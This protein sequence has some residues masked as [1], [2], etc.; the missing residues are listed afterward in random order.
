MDFRELVNSRGLSPYRLET[1]TGIR[2]DKIQ[3][4]MSGRREPSLKSI[5]KIAKAL[6]CHPVEVFESIYE[7]YL[8]TKGK[9]EVKQTEVSSDKHTSV[10]AL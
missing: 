2:H 5:I 10:T 8:K 6:N 4:Y 3:H 7:T 9:N 1:M